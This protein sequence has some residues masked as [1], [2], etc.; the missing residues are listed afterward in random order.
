MASSIWCCAL[1]LVTMAMPIKL[2]SLYVSMICPLVSWNRLDEM[3]TPSNMSLQPSK[4]HKNKRFELCLFAD[5]LVAFG[6][7]E[8]A[9]KCD[10]NWVDGCAVWIAITEV[11]M[12]HMSDP[13]ISTV[14]SLGCNCI[15]LIA[16]CPG[17]CATP[18]TASAY[19]HWRLDQIIW[20]GFYS[21]QWWCLQWIGGLTIVSFR[22]YGHSDCAHGRS[23]I[24]IGHSLPIRI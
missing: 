11:M 4:S 14:F 1:G 8:H 15:L 16:I 12:W 21:G 7:Q 13:H 18:Q 22:C 10:R 23:E 17:D 9:C 6:L 5:I 19:M 3:Y 20:L 2:D 24:V